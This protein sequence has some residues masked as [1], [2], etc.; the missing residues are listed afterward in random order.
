MATFR[1]PKES[2]LGWFGGCGVMLCTGFNNYMITDHSGTL[3]PEKG[4]LL[5]NNSWIGDG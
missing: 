1:S 3:L 5:A 2:Q 4:M